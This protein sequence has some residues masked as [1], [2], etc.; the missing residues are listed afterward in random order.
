MHWID[1]VIFGCYFLAII[2]VGYYFLKQNQ[3]R[4]D[5]YVGGRNI[6]AGHVG[7]SIAATD[8]GGGFSIG[9]GGLGFTMGLSGSWLLFTGL[10]GAWIAA[11]LTVPKLKRLDIESGLLT[12]PDFLILKYNKSVGMLAAIISGIGYIGFTAGQILAG[13]KLAAASVF[14]DVTWTDPLFF[15]LVVMSLVV[16]IYTSIGGIKAVIYTDTI[17]WIVLLS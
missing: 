8:V 6:K 10:I 5:Y 13:G 12:F 16:V 15:S 4:E 14:Q 9:L 3:S 1:Y 2:Y 17:Q 7:L 11:V